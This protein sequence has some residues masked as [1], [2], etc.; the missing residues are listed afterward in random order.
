MAASAVT[1]APSGGSAMARSGSLLRGSDISIS[2]NANSVT[3][4]CA[5]SKAKSRANSKFSFGLTRPLNWANP[6][7]NA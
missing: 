1:N 3:C 6:N 2:G 4:F 5:A 7:V